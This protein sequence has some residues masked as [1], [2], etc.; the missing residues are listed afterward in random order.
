MLSETRYGL[1]QL[2]TLLSNI[3]SSASLI[4]TTDALEEITLRPVTQGKGGGT[5]RHNISYSTR[6]Q[7]FDIKAATFISVFSVVVLG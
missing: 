7:F 2:E 3:S 6:K 1:I 5:S 4:T